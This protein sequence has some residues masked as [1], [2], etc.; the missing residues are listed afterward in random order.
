M[1]WLDPASVADA[2]AFLA[3]LVRLDPTA[4]VRMRPAGGR[5]LE[6][7]ARLPFEVLVT[8][9]VCADLAEDATVRAADLLDALDAGADRLPPRR[10]AEWRWPLPPEAGLVVERL[11]VAELHRVGA[12]AE[13][14]LRAAVTGGVR[15]RA[16]GERVLR[17]ALL[18]H[19]PVVVIT[20]DGTRVDVPQRLVQGVVRMGFLGAAPAPGEPAGG[21]VEVR[22]A[23]GWVGLAGAF[24]TGW[25]RSSRGLAV[26]PTG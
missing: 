14:T 22:L 11:P 16:V 25:H 12:A 5:T 17:D 1:S 21:A 15:G 8:R 2:G 26:R 20:D 19:V 10:D 3:R 13:A 7:W 23:R 6:L 24:G 9:R 18:D 4:L